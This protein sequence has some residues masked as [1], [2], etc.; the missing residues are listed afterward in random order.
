MAF[1]RKKQLPPI[2]GPDLLLL[3]AQQ[4]VETGNVSKDDAQPFL[5]M[6]FTCFDSSLTASDEM[7]RIAQRPLERHEAAA[8][9]AVFNAMRAAEANADEETYAETVRVG[10]SL[11]AKLGEYVSAGDA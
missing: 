10:L 2:T 7:R 8:V 11:L 9:M 4:A 5:D 6:L 1:G 3:S